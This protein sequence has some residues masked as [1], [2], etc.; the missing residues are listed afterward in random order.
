MIKLSIHGRSIKIFEFTERNQK[1]FYRIKVD[2]KLRGGAV[3]F[4]LKSKKV[5]NSLIFQLVELSLVF[6]I[7]KLYSS[8]GQN[9]VLRRIT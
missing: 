8:Y 4:I 2:A 9:S 1:F 7:Q 6:L 5:K 3:D